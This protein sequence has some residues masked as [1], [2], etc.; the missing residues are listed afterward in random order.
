MGLVLLSVIKHYTQITDFDSDFKSADTCI[1]N[2]IYCGT[3]CKII[4]RK[5]KFVFE[6]KWIL[7][8]RVKHQVF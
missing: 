2:C 3:L 6:Q 1:L 8:D 4:K 7:A 5:S